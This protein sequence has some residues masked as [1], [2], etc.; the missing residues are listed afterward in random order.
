M[1][2]LTAFGDW[3]LAQ[4]PVTIS[5]EEYIRH[6]AIKPQY[7]WPKLLRGKG[8][9]GYMRLGGGTSIQEKVILSDVAT[10]QNYSPNDPLTATMPQALSMATSYFKFGVDK[11][12]WTQNEE[13]LNMGA[14]AEMTREARAIRYVRFLT[15]KKTE[16]QVSSANGME[17][18]LFSVPDPTAMDAQSGLQANSFFHLINDFGSNSCLWKGVGV[19]FTTKHGI[20]PSS[21]TQ[22]LFRN[23]VIGYND[24]VANTAAPNT[25]RNLVD[26]F[27]AAMIRLNYV[28][29]APAQW[30]QAPQNWEDSKWPDK[31]ALLSWTGMQKIMWILRARNTDWS[32]RLNEVGMMGP[33]CNGVELFAIPALETAA[34][35]PDSYTTPTG[36]FTEGSSSGAGRGPRVYICDKSAIH[37]F[38]HPEKFFKA[39]EPRAFDNQPFTFA[40]WFD[41]YY[42]FMVT[43][44][45]LC[46]VLSPSAATMGVD[47]TLAGNTYLPG[48]VYTY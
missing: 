45:W 44:P 24:F 36:L 37:A 19:A 18:S 4:S 48:T 27:D 15:I 30:A 35:Y 29:P 31:Y 5:P 14:T 8:A 28:A 17:N 47:T 10:F 12:A 39:T 32:A 23:W 38:I 7:G 3:L 9:D 33:V 11:M 2:A 1:P 16:V 22:N 25:N 41:L 34:V 43:A 20:T 21:A 13:L 6:A 26:A 46:A 42:Q 40:V